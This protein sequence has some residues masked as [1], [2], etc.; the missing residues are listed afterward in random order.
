MPE[1][2]AERYIPA[3]PE[4]VYR[5][6]KDLE[7]LK[8]YLKEVESLEVVARE[9]ARTRSRWVAVAMGKKVRWLG[10][11]E[12]DDENL[13]NRFFSPEGDFDRYE[14]TWVFLPEGEGT[15]VVLT[16]TYELTIP[17]FGGLLRKLVQK[18]MQENVESLLKG[19]EERVLAA[20][21]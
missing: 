2:R 20:S 11:E 21:S 12:W 13:R 5:L 8:P 17:I 7:G 9:G 6:A 19:L 10:A 1:V 15:R 4:R 18:L 3:P 16:L 14:G